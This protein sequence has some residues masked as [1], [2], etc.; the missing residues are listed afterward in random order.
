[1]KAATIKGPNKPYLEIKEVPTPKPGPGEILVRVAATGICHSDLH[2]FKGDFGPV[3]QGFI[4]GHEI[5]GWVEDFGPDVKNPWG[6]KKGDPVIISWIVPDGICKYCASGKENYCPAA[7]GRMPGLVGLNG[8]HAEYITVPEIAVIPLEKGV[9]VY[10][11]APIACAYG[12]AYH[13]LREAGVGPGTSLVVIGVGGVGLSAVQLASAMG[14]YPIIA[15]DVRD[16]ALD[17][18]R[19]LGA[20]HVINS[21]KEDPISRIRDILP[22]GADV[23]HEARPEPDLKLSMEVVARAGTIVVT[24]LGGPKSYFSVNILPFVVNG[25]RIIGSLGYRPRL[26]LPEIIKLVASGKVDIRKLVSHVYA[27]E[28]INEAYEN[29]EKGLHARAIVKWD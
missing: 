13:A 19:E 6:L 17:K 12:T 23:V 25:I 15:V 27:P 7:A 11:A 4:P 26:D 5:S 14:A 22:D 8:G 10:Y 28:Q 3:R 21:S 16:Y 2:L 20:T 1:M 18:A 24:G 29:L 9:D